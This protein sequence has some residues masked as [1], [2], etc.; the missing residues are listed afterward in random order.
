MKLTVPDLKLLNRVLECG[1][2]IERAWPYSD[3]SV[4]QIRLREFVGLLEN[5]NAAES[6]ELRRLSGHTKHLSESMTARH[7]AGFLVAF[8]RL[9]NRALRDDEFL[10][11]EGD[12]PAPLSTS[13]EPVMVI[14][15][16]IR[17]SFNVGAIFRTAECFNI[18]EILL[19]GYTATPD[20]EKTARTSMGTAASVEWRSVRETS[21]AVTEAKLRGFSVI[22]LETVDAAVD[23]DDF[24][25]PEKCAILI[26]NER[27]GV[28]REALARADHIVKIPLRGKKNSLN[29]GISLGIALHSR[30]QKPRTTQPDKIQRDACAKWELKPIGIFH[31]QSVHPYEAPRQASEDQS[32]LEGIIELS[33]N[34]PA[35][36]RD[37][38]DNSDAKEDGSSEVHVRNL[39]LEQALTD[40]EGFD[41][42]WLLYRF[43]HNQNWKPMVVPPRGPA[44]KR[45]VF[46]TRAPYR[47]NAIGL[48]AVR[49]VRIEGRKLYIR[50]FDLLD[51]TPIYDIK[52]Y[53]AYADSHPEAALGWLEGLDE[54]ANKIRFS[55]AAEEQM[56]WLEANGM[57]QLRGFI[58]SQL[59][60]DA[61]DSERKRIS[62]SE[63]KGIHEIAYRTWR[64]SFF[65]DPDLKSIS[66]LSIYSGY[67]D[68]ELRLENIENPHGDKDLHVAFNRRS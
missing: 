45:G 21:M 44:V 27:F 49:L 51:Q 39:G 25:W 63:I 67:S 50:G 7:L 38:S 5:L 47:P 57:S 43:H 8:E 23:I 13:S 20:D 48:S 31:S 60:F 26:G 16:N 12:R 17:S 10:V 33:S 32:E 6:E 35:G 14:A 3:G 9:S 29:V 65:F 28:D 41:R 62:N 22:A 68:D 30:F 18:Q 37:N 53:L 19:T 66:I 58:A 59:R 15:D 4:A 61:L 24:A 42:I 64:V 34:F 55:P 1:H 36:P 2:Q 11:V 56:D 46:A 40:L 54:Q 52:P